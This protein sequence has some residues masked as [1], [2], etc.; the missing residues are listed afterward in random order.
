MKGSFPSRAEEGETLLVLEQELLPSSAGHGQHWLKDHSR[1]A[2]GWGDGAAVFRGGRK[3][4]S[5]G[6]KEMCFEGT[7]KG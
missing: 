5:C 2:T 6:A 4:K 7:G 3:Q 1:G